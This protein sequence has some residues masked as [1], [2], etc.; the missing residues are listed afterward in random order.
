MRTGEAVMKLT[1]VHKTVA[2]A[3]KVARALKGTADV[4]A[5]ILIGWKA[6]DDSEPDGEGLE[7]GDLACQLQLCPTSG[8][9]RDVPYG[10]A[11]WGRIAPTRAYHD[12]NGGVHVEGSVE[13]EPVFFG[14]SA[15]IAKEVL[16]A[17][18][19]EAMGLGL[20]APA[21][22]AYP[23]WMRAGPVASELPAAEATTW[24][25]TPLDTAIPF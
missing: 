12:G 21:L 9:T 20:V 2:G 14:V 24:H 4:Y 8:G 3:R 18:V 19:I 16:P 10:R 1:T 5:P 11:L 15:A 23:E 13:G 22:G 7:F 6:P 17:E 25:R